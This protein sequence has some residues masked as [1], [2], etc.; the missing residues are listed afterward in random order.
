MEHVKKWAAQ[1]GVDVNDLTALAN[2]NDL[3]KAIIAEMDQKAKESKFTSLEKIKKIHLTFEQF[4]VSNDIITPT[5][6]IKRNVAKK[7]FIKE[8][9]QMYAEPLVQQ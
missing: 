9:E 7:T 8:I 3:K 2:N 1:H 4:S 5:F 6:K